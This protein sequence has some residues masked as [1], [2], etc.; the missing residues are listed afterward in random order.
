MATVAEKMRIPINARLRLINGPPGAADMLGA[1]PAGVQ[2]MDTAAEV[3]A[4]ILFANDR[5]A[6]E[7]HLAE[8]VRAASGDRL[9]WVAYPK[10]GSGVATDLNRDRVAELVTRAG[11]TAVTQV[12]IDS[13][14]SAL[15]LRPSERYRPS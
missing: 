6:L 2:V 5:A 7:A 8:A 13:T 4:V 15:R 3:D 14:W 11:V 1:L 12:A 10:G 9:L